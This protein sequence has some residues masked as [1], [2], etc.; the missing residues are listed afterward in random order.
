MEQLLKDNSILFE[1]QHVRKDSSMIPVEVSAKVVTREGNGIIQGFVRNIT[2]RKEAEE[3]IQKRV[4]E[5]EDFYDMAIGRELR[6]IELKEEIAN[7]K[8]ELAKYRKPE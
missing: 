6:M 5:L 1:G 2:E 4:K 8:E 7:L 3:E